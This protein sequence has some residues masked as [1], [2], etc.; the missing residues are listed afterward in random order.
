[1]RLW[2]FAKASGGH[3]GFAL[4]LLDETLVFFFASL[5]PSPCTPWFP[6][7][8]GGATE[9]KP[10]GECR[11]CC[12]KVARLNGRGTSEALE[13]SIAPFELTVLFEARAI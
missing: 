4:Y 6:A 2:H 5:P 8:L 1:M 12:G 3:V 7:S 10:F 11:K 9:D 13:D